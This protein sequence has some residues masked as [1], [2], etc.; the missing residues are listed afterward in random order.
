MNNP[1]VSIIIPTYNRSDLLLQTLESVKDQTYKN[2]ECIIVDDGSTDDTS[3]LV[4]D[5]CKNDSRFNYYRRPEDRIKGANTCRNLGFELSKGAYINW[6]DDDD[7][8][9][10]QFLSSKVEVLDPELDLVICSCSIV[11][12]VLANP[13]VIE[14]N[15]DA[16]LYRD[17]TLWKLKLI[18]HCVLFKRS[19]LEDKSLF[20]LKISRG[21][22]TELFSRLFFNLQKDSY[23]ILNESLFLYRQHSGTKTD[24]SKEYVKQY[25]YSESYIAAQNLKR[26]FLSKDIQV[27]QASYKNLIDLFFRGIENKHSENSWYILRQINSVLP[28]KNIVLS[29]KLNTYCLF[30][31]LIGR[32]SY[33]IE[34]GLKKAELKI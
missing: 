19:F 16:D 33:R 4:L 17:F 14:L 32:G 6:F 7:I 23:K 8:M 30:C 18:T 11:D 1:L 28:I 25:K 21:Q 3:E 29:I 26:G 9:L 2:W 5:Y 22:E 20:S 10:P 27:V 12:D 34:Q 31:M 24:K 15:E 13:R